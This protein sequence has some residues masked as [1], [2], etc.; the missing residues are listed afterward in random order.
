MSPGCGTGATQLPPR[1]AT[2]KDVNNER[3]RYTGRP[4]DRKTAQ[5]LRERTQPASLVHSSGNGAWLLT[6]KIAH[7]TVDKELW[8]RY[9]LAKRGGGYGE[10]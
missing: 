9:I 7:P 1:L 5:L 6:Q 4:Q 10:R 2:E 3:Q 8:T